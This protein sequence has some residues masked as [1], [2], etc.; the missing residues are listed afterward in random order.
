MD[1]LIDFLSIKIVRN[2]K[3]FGIYLLKVEY[4]TGKYFTHDRA[5]LGI[6]W[7][8]NQRLFAIDILFMRWSNFVK[9]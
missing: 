5:L 3:Y 6:F 4:T 7:F 9:K 2:W 1:L 8:G